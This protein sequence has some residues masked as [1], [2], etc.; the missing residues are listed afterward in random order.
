MQRVEADGQNRSE[1]HCNSGKG[2]GTFQAGASYIQGL[3]NC[4]G[5]FGEG[6]RSFCAV[7][8]GAAF[9][10]GC[11]SERESAQSA[12]AKKG[13]VACTANASARF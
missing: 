4:T 3:D 1:R 5:R 10:S 11:A 8:I 2:S 12:A 7:G 6:R 13:G 9:E